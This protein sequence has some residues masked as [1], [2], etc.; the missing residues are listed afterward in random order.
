MKN[1][2]WKTIIVIGVLLAGTATQALAQKK[3]LAGT[4]KLDNLT[5]VK[6]SDN[7]T[8]E[9]EK[10]RQNLYFDILD[11]LVFEGSELTITYRGAHMDGA[12]EITA[13]KIMIPFTAAPIELQYQLKDGRLFLE[14]RVQGAAALN[15]EL[16]IIS[17]QY[18]KN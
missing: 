6:S 4:W 7:T 3:L 5:I 8:V 16:Y 17:T 15:G 13:D 11:T 1:L 12:V 18:K 10:V 2:K 9:L 14:Q